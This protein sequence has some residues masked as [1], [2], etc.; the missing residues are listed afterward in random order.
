MPTNF[1]ATIDTVATLPNPGATD[2]LANSVANLQHA[3]QH[4]TVND[5][6]RALETKMGINGSTDT[7]SI[8]YKLS[9]ATG[10]SPRAFQ[11]VTTAS[12]APGAADAT[13][14]LT[15]GKA[16]DVLS[17]T[18]NYPAWV[19]LY[20]SAASQAADAGRVITNDPAPGNGVTCEATTATGLL[21]VPTPGALAYSLDTNALTTITVSIV[22]KDSA[23]RQITL[24][25]LYV[26]QEG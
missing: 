5:A 8:D 12:L 7:S 11:T 19:R 20:T 15:L 13:Q 16:A 3:Y 21:T 17:I 4:D 1:P 23:A 10:K 9:H 25:V 14:V 6:V 26:S 22:N 18:T 24:T 2:L